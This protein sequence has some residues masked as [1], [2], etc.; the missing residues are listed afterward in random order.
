MFHNIRLIWKRRLV[1]RQV[2]STVEVNMSNLVQE[3][4]E[5]VGSDSSYLVNI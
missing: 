3:I 2:A 1:I 5:M 4:K